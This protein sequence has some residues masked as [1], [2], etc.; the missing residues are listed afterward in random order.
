MRLELRTDEKIEISGGYSDG[1]I[2]I[3]LNVDKD[4]LLELIAE[5][6]GEEEIIKKLINLYGATSFLDCI[7]IED[8]KDYAENA[9]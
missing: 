8:I 2:D 5:E 3:S 1:S 7:D 4:N 9:W 6:L